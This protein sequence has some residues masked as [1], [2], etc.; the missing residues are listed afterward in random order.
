MR[1]M[2]QAAG[3]DRSDQPALVDF[4]FDQSGSARDQASV[5]A[6]AQPARQARGL[7]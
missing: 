2:H 5:S 3:S 1:G 4:G 6:P 7:D